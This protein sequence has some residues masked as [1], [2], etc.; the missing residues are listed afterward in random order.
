MLWILG[1]EILG[2]K[3]FLWKSYWGFLRLGCIVFC[4]N[5][6]SQ[7]RQNLI[8]GYM[9]EYYCELGSQGFGFKI[10]YMGFI[11]ISSLLMFHS[12]LIVSLFSLFVTIFIHTELPA[13]EL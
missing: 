2:Y 10:C 8:L 1:S 3:R 13:F 7:N 5:F 9:E 12:F 4:K 6:L 11:R